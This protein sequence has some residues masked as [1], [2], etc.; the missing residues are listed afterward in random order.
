MGTTLVG[1][2]QTITETVSKDLEKWATDIG[3]TLTNLLD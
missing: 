1:E 3:N 2:F